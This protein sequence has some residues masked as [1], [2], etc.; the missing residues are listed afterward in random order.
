MHMKHKETFTWTPEGL[1]QFKLPNIYKD[2]LKVTK[3][4][5]K[6]QIVDGKKLFTLRDK[7]REKKLQ[8]SYIILLDHL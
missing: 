4:N 5:N 6:V 2:E 3:T 7:W 1:Y 8:E